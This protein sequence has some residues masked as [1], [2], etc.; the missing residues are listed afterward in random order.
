M[1]KSTDKCQCGHL[2]MSHVYTCFIK[3]CGCIKFISNKEKWE[4][5]FRALNNAYTVWTSFKHWG[6]ESEKFF[7]ESENR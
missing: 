7:H 5:N 6:C 2:E 3:G 1:R 4:M